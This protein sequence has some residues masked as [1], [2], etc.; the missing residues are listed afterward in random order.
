MTPRAYP[1]AA[2]CKC[3][4][5]GTLWWLGSSCT[6][7]LCCEQI[8]LQLSLA[9][10][11]LLQYRGLSASSAGI[12][13]AC[14]VWDTRVF[15]VVFQLVRLCAGPCLSQIGACKSK[16]ESVDCNCVHMHVHIC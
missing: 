3:P 13:L 16:K 11:F 15:R 2:K 10:C 6:M 4:A 8:Y 7:H 5:C 14:H 9:S 12:L 1:C